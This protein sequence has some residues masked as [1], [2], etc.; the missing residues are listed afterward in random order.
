MIIDLLDTWFGAIIFISFAVALSIAGLLLVRRRYTTEQLSELHEVA[1]NLLSVLGTMYA[2]LVALVVVDAMQNMA[3]ARV[4]TE[5]EANALADVYRLAGGLPEK[6][7]KPLRAQCYKYCQ[8]VIN[9]EWPAM[10]YGKES[11]EAW[12]EL[13]ALW[14]LVKECEPASEREKTFYST[15]VTEM[16]SLGDGRRTR[17]VACRHSMSGILW[18]VLLIGGGVT[19]NFTYFFAARNLKAQIVMTAFVTFTIATNLFLIAEYGYP[20]RGILMVEPEGFQ[21]DLE[22]FKE[23]AI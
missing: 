20:F 23:N 14:N 19:I 12:I 10:A 9:K 18:F 15:L 16:T 5:L 13:N 22:R 1:G 8:T 3:D 2:L 11:P 21:M 7:V 4:T 17:I 6:Y